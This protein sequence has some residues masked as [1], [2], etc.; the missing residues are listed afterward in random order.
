MDFIGSTLFF[1]IGGVLVAGLIGI[2]VFMRIK[3][4]KDDE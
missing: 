2:L 4:K 1:V 3:A